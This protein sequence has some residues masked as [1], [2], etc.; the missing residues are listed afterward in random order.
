MSLQCYCATCGALVGAR[1]V[2]VVIEGP[3]TVRELR[4]YAHTNGGWRRDAAGK[5]TM[6]PPPC[7]GHKKKGKPA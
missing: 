1:L 5:I 6:A 2:R 3:E 7:D 4:P